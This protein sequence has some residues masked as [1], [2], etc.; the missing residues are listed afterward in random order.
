MA[1]LIAF[2][3]TQYVSEYWKREALTVHG[4]GSATV[5]EYSFASAEGSL[6][7][8]RTSWH[9]N[10]RVD[11]DGGF[12][13]RWEYKY[14]QRRVRWIARTEYG[15]LKSTNYE[16]RQPSQAHRRIG[17]AMPWLMVALV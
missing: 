10:N 14:D 2:V 5:T 6:I 9:Y 16:S 11:L 13:A 7:V 4:D 12:H 8:G 1:A 15:F 17:I 3:R